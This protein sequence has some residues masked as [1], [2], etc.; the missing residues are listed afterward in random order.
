MKKLRLA[1]CV[2]TY[3]RPAELRRGLP[4]VL[5]HVSRLNGHEDVGI[6]ADVLVVDND[7]EGSAAQVVREM[8]SPLITYVV[9]PEPGISAGRNR[10]LDEALGSDLL[11]YID[12]DERPQERWLLPLVQ[13]WKESGAAA[14]MGRVVSEFEHEVDPWITAGRFFVRRRMATGTAIDVAAA[15]NLLLDLNQIRDLGIRFD[16]SFGLT[17]AEDTLFSG[18]LRNAGGKIVWCDESVASDF[19]PASRTTR[20]WVL[21]RSWSHGN[22]AT[23]VDL[24]LAGS[25]RQQQL[26]RLR[27]VARGLLRVGGGAARYGWGLVTRSDRHEARGLRAA[28]RGAGMIAGAGG[29]VYQE[30]GRNKQSA[31]SIYRPFARRSVWSRWKIGRYADH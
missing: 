27:A 31:S 5:E 29:L 26:R 1:V 17:G 25:S 15:G 2:L 12:D 19:V 18:M 22:S 11:V 7:P 9:E 13:T 10:A 3:K 16:S 14:V 6:M 30:Y 20:K 28:M 23:L 24:K 21:A 4:H 8:D